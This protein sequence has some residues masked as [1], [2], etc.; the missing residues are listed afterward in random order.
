MYPLSKANTPSQAAGMFIPHA[1]THVMGSALTS[2]D[3]TMKAPNS[4]SATPTTN[5]INSEMLY[6]YI[7]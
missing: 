6:I 5:F 1:L 4:M 3:G 2:P 7:F